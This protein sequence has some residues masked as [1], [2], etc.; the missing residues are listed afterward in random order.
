MNTVVSSPITAEAFTKAVA[1]VVRAAAFA[2]AITVTTDGV[3][4]S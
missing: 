2:K 3:S 4:L 1:T